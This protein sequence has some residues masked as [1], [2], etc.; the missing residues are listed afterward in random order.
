L[1]FVHEAFLELLNTGH[2]FGDLFLVLFGLTHFLLLKLFDIH[3]EF[4]LL[5]HKPSH[6]VL[7]FEFVGDEGLEFGSGIVLDEFD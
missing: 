5:F 7:A 3:V 2:V 1:A 4:F 6:L